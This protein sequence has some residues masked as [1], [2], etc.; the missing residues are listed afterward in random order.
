M[1]THLV[2][3]RACFRRFIFFFLKEIAAFPSFSTWETL[4]PTSAAAPSQCQFW[5]SW[6]M[7]TSTWHWATSRTRSYRAED[8][9]MFHEL[10]QISCSLSWSACYSS[11]SDLSVLLTS[12]CFI[13]SSTSLRFVFLI[14]FFPCLFSSKQHVTKHHLTHLT[15]I[16]HLHLLFG[17]SLQLHFCPLRSDF[18]PIFFEHKEVVNFFALLSTNF[19]RFSAL[20]FAVFVSPFQLWSSETA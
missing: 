12:S 15:T 18:F 14:V 7:V 5:V 17:S 1:S 8:L 13:C 11:L 3:L 4:H 6:N 20:S 2:P 16:L 9:L 19:F 10:T